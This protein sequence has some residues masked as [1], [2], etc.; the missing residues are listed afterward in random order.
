MRT[1]STHFDNLF[2]QGSM[3]TGYRTDAVFEYKIEVTPITTP[4]FNIEND[5]LYGTVEW[6]D[7]LSDGDEFCVGNAFMGEFKFTLRD[8]E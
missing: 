8:I 6:I 7:G 1:R 4:P 5:K 3:A 2:N